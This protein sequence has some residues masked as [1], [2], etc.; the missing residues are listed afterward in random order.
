[1][2]LDQTLEERALRLQE[3]YTRHRHIKFPSPNALDIAQYMSYTQTYANLLNTKGYSNQ[4]RIIVP[5]ISHY[6]TCTYNSNTTTIC[7]YM[8]YSYDLMRIRQMYSGHTD[9][10]VDDHIGRDGES[11]FDDFIPIIDKFLPKLE[12][13]VVNPMQFISPVTK[14]NRENVRGM[15]LLSW[16][17]PP[18]YALA[19]M[20]GYCIRS[21]KK[22]GGIYA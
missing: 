12:E 8:L 7:A 6:F 13:C 3:S 10:M 22:Q 2:I 9:V 14:W 17:C 16:E 4:H 20:N 1:M 11:Y 15:S 19:A 21:N 18:L 5:G